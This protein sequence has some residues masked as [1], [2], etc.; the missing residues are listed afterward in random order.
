[1]GV[2]DGG[3]GFADAA[4]PAER[5]GLSERG[6]GAVRQLRMQSFEKLT[7]PGKKGV[8][9]EGHI[10]EMHARGFGRREV[11]RKISTTHLEEVS[12]LLEVLELMF[13]QIKQGHLLWESMLYQ[14]MCGLREQDLS[15]V[16]RAHDAG[17]V[18]DIEPHVAG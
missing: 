18:M 11:S 15:S 9:P 7:A 12:R 4:Q 10:P 6:T 8:A 17:G 5:V 1:M 13:S 2:L 16:R 14:L 3:L